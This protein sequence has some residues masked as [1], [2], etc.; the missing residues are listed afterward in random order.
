MDHLLRLPKKIYFKPGSMNV[1]LRELTEVYGC[2]RALLVTEPGL[3]ASGAARP[4]H[5]WLR[6]LGIRTAE[7]F[8]IGET[9]TVRE[10]E[11]ALPKT[12]VFRPDVIVGFGG[13][14]A[15]S[16][17]KAL[18]ALYAAPD[19]ELGKAELGLFD[20]DTL[21]VLIGADLSGA[22][23]TPYA[24]LRDGEGAEL[25]L[26]S[27]DLLPEISVTDAHFIDWMT[28][29][30]IRTG[31]KDI[32]ESSARAYAE[33][34]SEY[35]RGFLLDAADAALRHTKAAVEGCP[36]AREA[37]MD[38]AAL[39]GMA[40]GN[41]PDADTEP[42]SSDALAEALGFPCGDALA[43]AFESSRGA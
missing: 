36:K 41:V 39:M 21:L 33:D 34:C 38:A 42:T 1:A 15:M 28:A 27:Y 16:A 40:C 43:E 13:V 20:P 17:A 31:A 25:V 32:L 2:R 5:D 29:E 14:A 3:Y 35:I 19:I 9:P 30:Q 11:S 23:N 10:I 24:V 37:L 26:R 7:F 6:K 18:Y 4:V 22:Q 12:Q 8:G